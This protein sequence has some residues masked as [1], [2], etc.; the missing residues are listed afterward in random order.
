MKRPI[1]SNTNSQDAGASQSKRTRPTTSSQP[2]EESV[3]DVNNDHVPSSSQQKSSKTKSHNSKAKPSNGSINRDNNSSG[4]TRTSSGS[5][6][7]F[8][9]S[10]S[11]LK[12]PPVATNN[13]TKS[14]P[15]INQSLQSPLNNSEPTHHS[16]SNNVD[17]MAADPNPKLVFYIVV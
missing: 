1:S 14:D 9:S 12:S 17:R 4:T 5:T 6:I 15:R 11:S 2:E 8:S 16:A 13:N 10:P 3:V 7:S